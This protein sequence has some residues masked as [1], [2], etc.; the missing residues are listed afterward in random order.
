MS[1]E[2]PIRLLTCK[3]CNSEYGKY[4]GHLAEYM[5]RLGGDFKRSEVTIGDV[6]TRAELTLTNSN[7]AI[8]NIARESA[9]DPKDLIR[10]AQYAQSMTH[11]DEIRLEF[12]IRINPEISKAILRAAYLWLVAFTG[13]EY[14]YTRAGRSI[15]ALMRSSEV[16]YPGNYCL[17]L[18]E[19]PD[20]V[21]NGPWHVTLDS[22]SDLSAFWVKIGGHLVVMPKAESDSSI[23]E[24]YWS[25][26]AHL[27]VPIGRHLNIG[28]KTL[29]ISAT[30]M[31]FGQLRTVLSQLPMKSR[32]ES[33]RK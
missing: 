3:S 7:I 28:I 1:R 2:R 33:G 11:G 24:R 30:N 26:Q 5:R 4:E 29:E 32:A 15:R 14:A 16:L 31:R 25:A 10:S 13:Y 22:P 17:R 21:N 23:F 9:N 12:S 8:A 6:T 19:A 27:D 18:V 20:V